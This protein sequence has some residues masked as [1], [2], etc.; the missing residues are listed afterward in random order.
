MLRSENG[1]LEQIVAEMKGWY[2]KWQSFNISLA[3]LIQ[4][5][6]QLAVV[7]CPL[8]PRSRTFIGRV[9]N[10]SAAPEGLLPPVDGAAEFLIE[11]FRNKTIAP[12]GLT[13]LVGAHTTSQQFFVDLDR[14]GDPQDSTPGVWDVLFYAEVLNQTTVPPRVFTF[15]SD[16][17]LS[18]ANETVG[19]WLEFANDGQED[20]NEVR[21]NWAPCQRIH[22]V[23]LIRNQDYARE[24]IRLSLLSVYGIN[25]MTECT[26]VLP[27]AI[28][29]FDEDDSTLMRIWRNT[30]VGLPDVAQAV[31]NG[32]L[33]TVS[34]FHNV[35]DSA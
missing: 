19:E 1:G 35:S 34:D 12:H 25:N 33:V 21:A 31:F 17:N 22:I 3:D 23:I 14:V 24:Y 5:A 9:D 8:G 30:T 32:S 15:Q 27:P 18:K 20:W 6:A 29:S 2:A 11:L 16:I 7:T 28:T 4:F 26:K 10:S 13:A